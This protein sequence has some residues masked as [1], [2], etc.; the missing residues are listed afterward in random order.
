M[1]LALTAK[2]E[3][4]GNTIFFPR[5]GDLRG[6]GQ[7]P[8]RF[9]ARR[10]AVDLNLLL[11]FDAL[12]QERSLTRAGRRLGF[13]QPATSRAL[14]RLRLILGDELF[15]RTAKGMLPTAR[16]E[17]MAESVGDALSVLRVAL[18][19]QAFDPAKSSRVFTVA[20]NNYAAHA[21]VPSLA[22]RMEAEGCSVRLDVLPLGICDVLDQ[23]ER[24]A[25]VAVT[26]LVDG[27]QQFKC[28]RIMED[29]LVVVLDRRH[30]AGLPADFSAEQLARIPH[31]AVSSADADTSFV[32]DAL[33]ERGLK[34]SVVARVPLPS[35][36]PMLLGCDRV[37]VL[38]RRV[39]ND[40]AQ[41][42]PLVVRKLPFASPRITLAM[43]WHRRLDNDPA[44][45]WLRE[46][47]RSSVVVRHSEAMTASSSSSNALA[48]RRGAVLK[49]SV[50]HA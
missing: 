49:P 2:T 40:L 47:V 50:N 46:T 48:R 3:L 14:A 12:V 43:I 17:Q 6:R 33:R 32:D 18:E 10:G 5:P 16:A 28:V 20:V 8:A 42:G 7:V 35:I 27:G 23:L 1:S 36:A 9:T 34:R 29:D 38:P 26:A 21:V 13:S 24:G 30:A 39:A 41:F 15:I 37:A 25:D 4:N 45:R 44:H 22:S 31:V 19:A 11:V